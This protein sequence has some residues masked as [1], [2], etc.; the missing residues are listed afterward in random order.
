MCFSVDLLKEHEYNSVGTIAVS[1]AQQDVRLR[2]EQNPFM[3]LNIRQVTGYETQKKKMKEIAH[4]ACVSC[5]PLPAN[6]HNTH[7]REE[8]TQCPNAQSSGATRTKIQ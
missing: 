7:G 5:C 1:Y 8:K 2:Q 6:P 4:R 3:H